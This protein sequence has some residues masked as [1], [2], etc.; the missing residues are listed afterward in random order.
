MR[1]R[2]KRHGN[3][4]IQA[5]AGYIIHSRDE[6]AQFP[7][8]LEIGCGKG[9]FILETARRHPDIM[10]VAMEKVTDVLML[11]AEKIKESGLT[12]VKL[13]NGGAEHLTEWFQKGDVK[14]IYLNFSDPWPKKKH[15][16]RRLTY[17]SFL[18]QYRVILTDDG[19][20]FFKTDNRGLFDFS[21]DEMRRCGY[22][23]KNLTYD[24]H[25]S[26][27]NEGNVVTEY[28]A[29]FSAKGYPINR[30][31]AAVDPGY[32]KPQS[33]QNE[34]NDNPNQDIDKNA[35]AEDKSN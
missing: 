24:L 25:N 33:T 14:R 23:L 15:T 17:E 8:Y 16:K 12:N 22:R 27:W 26:E 19:E 32:I 4:R 7:I 31:E 5:C 18:D 28:E 35:D 3:E 13:W 1:I 6:I 21:V 10:F 2:K 9:A 29:N 11:A 34:T 20:I 30:V